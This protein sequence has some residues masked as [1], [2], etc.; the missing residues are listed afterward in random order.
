M[1]ETIEF[2]KL[3][4]RVTDAVRRLPE[5]AAAL[6]V[7]FSK[8]RFR[9]GNWLDNGTEP[10]KKRGKS[11]KKDNRKGRAILVDTGRL[12]RSI[13]KVSVTSDRAV[14][15]TDVPYA[16][17]HNDGFRGAVQQQVRSHNRSLTHAGIIR[18][19][20]LKRSTRISV[21]RIKHGNTIVK[22]FTRTIHQN[23]PRRRFIGPSA[24]L[25]KQLERLMTAEIIKSMKRP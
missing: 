15:G 18:G 11:W 6:A 23:T 25:N 19:K 22:A 16:R 7:N 17:A 2:M 14:I 13:R 1:K 10:W 9:A 3:V 20:E 5:Q 12:R 8:E 21:G 24:V 4:N